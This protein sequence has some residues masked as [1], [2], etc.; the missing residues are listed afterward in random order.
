M[1]TLSTFT[2]HSFGSPSYRNQR[3]EINKG[4]QI[5]REEVKLPLFADDIILYIEDVT[6]KLLELIDELLKLQDTKLIQ[7]SVAFQCTND[8]IS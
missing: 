7:S 1:L 2:E 3:E 8:E 6:R 4:I 5:E